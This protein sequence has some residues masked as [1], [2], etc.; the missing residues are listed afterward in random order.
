MSRG[1]KKIWLIFIAAILI[2]ATLAMIGLMCYGKYQISKIPELSFTEV[3]EYTTKDN[4]D[5]CITVGI[6]KDGRYGA[7]HC[8][9]RFLCWE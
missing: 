5:A 1:K 2:C 6:V 3:L 8:V 7:G 4:E 9:Y